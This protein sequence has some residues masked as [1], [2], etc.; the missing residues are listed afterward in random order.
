EQRWA[1]TLLERAM[2]QLRA[3][4]EVAG[5]ATE[6]DLLKE[7]LLGDKAVAGQVAVGESPGLTPGA[8]RVGLHRLRQ[9]VRGLGRSEVAHTVASPAAID[10]EIRYLAGVL[11]R[12][13]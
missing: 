9:R 7:C 3:E 5:K 10:D 12:A 1:I 2:A 4:Q 6:F 13:G 8:P 11:S